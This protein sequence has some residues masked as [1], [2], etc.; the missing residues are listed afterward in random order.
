M[1]EPKPNGASVSVWIDGVDASNDCVTTECDHIDTQWR[2]P[3]ALGMVSPMREGDQC[4]FKNGG[5]CRFLAAKI[6]AM[7]RALAVVRREIKRLEDEAED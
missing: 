7:K 1:S 3:F 2:C 4:G 5:D 6:A